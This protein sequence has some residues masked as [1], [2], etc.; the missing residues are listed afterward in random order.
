MNHLGRQSTVKLSMIKRSTPVSNEVQG[1]FLDPDL[2]YSCLL[3]ICFYIQKL[4]HF[5]L[6][7]QIN[8]DFSSLCTKD[9]FQHIHTFMWVS[10]GKRSLK[11]DKPYF[12]FLRR[13]RINVAI[14]K[15]VCVCVCVCLGVAWKDC[16]VVLFSIGEWKRHPSW[17]AELLRVEAD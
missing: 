13:V 9:H 16:E 5:S 14:Y 6:V 11:R 12:L 7:S 10:R 4:G 1:L 15:C 2:P 8:F 3:F 17:K